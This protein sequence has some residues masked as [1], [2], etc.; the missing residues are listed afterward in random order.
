MKVPLSW[1]QEYVPITV[2]PV[3]LA[4]LLTMAG[5]ETT[6]VPGPSSKLDNILVGNVLSVERHPNADRLSLVTVDI[7]SEILR[8]VCGA[9]NVSLDLRVA[10][11]RIGTTL[12]DQKSGKSFTLKAVNIRGVES[13]GMLCSEYEL[14]LGD[15]HAGIIELPKDAPIGT[16]LEHYLKDDVFDVE[17][18]AN[19]GDCLSILG[20]AREVSALTG[21][22]VTEP[23]SSY[24][25]SGPAIDSLISVKI[26]DAD[27]CSRPPHASNY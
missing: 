13:N 1:L 20:I 2:S 8:I 25:E 4:H 26:T 23:G 24:I 9:P 6:Y 12:T 11:A 22:E 3:E 27:L 16:S 21:V 5:I 17:I 7:N 19:R 14:G 18:T 10:V 15:D